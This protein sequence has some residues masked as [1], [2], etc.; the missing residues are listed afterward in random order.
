MIMYR[1][2]HLQISGGPKLARATLSRQAI[3]EPC[4]GG[5]YFLLY[6]GIGVLHGNNLVSLNELSSVYI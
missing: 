1:P 5:A 3:D 4:A 6:N 2:S